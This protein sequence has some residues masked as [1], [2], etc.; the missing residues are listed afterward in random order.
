MTVVEDIREQLNQLGLDT[1]GN[2]SALKKRLRK[3][4]KKDA[5]TSFT[6]DSNSSDDDNDE[7]EEGTTSKPQKPLDEKKQ[8]QKPS[9]E[10]KQPQKQ[11]EL[12][13]DVG[14]SQ[15]KLHK[16]SR[17][18]YYLCFDVEA[19]CELGFRFEFPSEVIEFPIVL[20][21]GSTLEIVDEFHSYVRPIHRP[22]LSDFCKELTGISQETVDNAP[23]FVEV[24]A[25]FE[26]WLTSH[27]IILS[28][29]DT[30]AS[31][32]ITAQPLG[33]KVKSKKSKNNS[34]RGGSNNGSPS[35]LQVANAVN[36]FKYGATYSFVTDGPFDIRDFISKQ[37]LH[38]N[39]LRPSYFAHPY[40][41]VRTMFRD[42]FDLIQWK[43][44]ERMLGFLGETFEGRQHS[45]I[46]DARMV[47]L[48]AKRLAQG[49]RKDQND[50]IFQEE[51][52][53]LVAPQWSGEKIAKFKEG[54]VLKANRSTNN[55]FIKMISFKK[56]AQ[57][58]AL[59]AAVAAGKVAPPILPKPPT[60]SQVKKDADDD[61]GPDNV[62]AVKAFSL[63]S[64]EESAPTSPI[65]ETFV[66]ESK[67]S[68]LSLSSE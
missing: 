42:Y 39:I 9:D 23:T 46:C 59:P 21:D 25:R 56:V 27:G 6:K 13:Q 24:L 49:F 41:D 3:H 66:S 55:T 67:F 58:E 47:A 34:G 31:T 36:D 37:C 18:D 22:I 43:N 51:N 30:T 17:Y 29:N 11:Q 16:N 63:P 62:P 50:P 5:K 19:T 26:D 65:V 52:T 38:S 68:A 33:K 64:P 57:I 61:K 35:N 12:E 2:K 14:Q 7:D 48:I 4:L 10:K 40:I 1:R 28:D 44:L 54:C 15:K 32:T 60:G 20:L 53:E 8:Q 45:G